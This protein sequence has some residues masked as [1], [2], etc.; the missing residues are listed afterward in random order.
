[1]HTKF[2]TPLCIFLSLA[3]IDAANATTGLY[4]GGGLGYGNLTNF[5]DATKAGKQ[6]GLAG[7]VF[8]GFNINEFVGLEA[9][10]SKFAKTTYKLNKFKE[11]TI[12]YNLNILSFVV[13]GYLPIENTS[14]KFLGL[15]GLGLAEGSAD[16]NYY[17]KNIQSNSH[18]STVAVVGLGGSYAI[19]EHMI[20]TLEYTGTQGKS[21]NDTTLG[22]PYSN[23]LT[24]NLAYQI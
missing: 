18:R 7:K 19:S 13:K 23:L 3:S 24:L 14:F 5:S 22:I 8:A 15:I 12:D 2:Q 6:G 10:Y 21:G 16:F 4:F 1:M 9:D 17:S 11:I 20:T